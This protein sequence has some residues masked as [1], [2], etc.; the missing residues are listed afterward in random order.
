[1]VMKRTFPMV[2][3]A[4]SVQPVTDYPSRLLDMLQEMAP[5]G[6]RAPI[7]AVWTPGIYNSAYFEHSFPRPADGCPAGRGERPGHS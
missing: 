2:F 6:I 5:A 7:V 1:M 4:C 3:D